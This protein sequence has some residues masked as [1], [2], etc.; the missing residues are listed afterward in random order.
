[1]SDTTYVAVSANGWGKGNHETD[2]VMN[3]V[4]HL[5][6]K[7]AD[8]NITLVECE[9]FHGFEGLSIEAD[10]ILSEEELTCNGDDVARLSELLTDA[11]I[12]A[13]Q[14]LVDAADE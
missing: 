11:E 4:P 6:T 8:V 3:L 10:E 9:N 13:E 12:L 14:I 1:M 2:A 7:G 5:R